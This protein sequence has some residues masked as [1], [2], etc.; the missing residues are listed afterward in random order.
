MA[1]Q[2][3]VD[4]LAP[5]ALVI[6]QFELD[7]FTVSH[8][9]SISL[10]DSIASLPQPKARGPIPD[11]AIILIRAILDAT[12]PILRG[13]RLNSFE[14]WQ[15]VKIEK[16]VVGLVAEVKRRP[17]RSA[18]SPER[19]AASLSGRLQDA[20]VEAVDQAAAAFLGNE[21]TNRLLLLAWSGEW[22]SW[23]LAVRKDSRVKAMPR[24]Q[25]VPEDEAGE[26]HEEAEEVPGEAE[27]APESNAES[28]SQVGSH[29][30]SSE[31]PDRASRSQEAKVE[32][33]YAYKDQLGDV[34]HEKIPY[35][36][37]P[38]PKPKAQQ[39]KSKSKGKGKETEKTKPPP[40]PKK[41]T[42][43]RY[44]PED[45][46]EVMETQRLLT[47]EEC[48][49][50]DLFRF[51]WSDPILFG[52]PESKQNWSLI[53]RFL[54][55]GNTRLNKSKVSGEHDASE[56]DHDASEDDHDAS[57]DDDAS[58]DEDYGDQNEDGGHNEDEDGNLNEVTQVSH[59]IDRHLGCT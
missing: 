22:Y 16:L 50:P 45:L 39:S 20:L 25:V 3:L 36:P 46:A 4:D 6:P 42:F 28:G 9:P 24:R 40:K 30:L 54:E 49:D 2:N 44:T 48:D 32:G 13:M 52:T 35:N 57:E 55:R 58:E 18:K 33:F 59:H 5:T 12:T 31:V 11:F 19:F 27:Q 8:P 41:A 34:A 15:K 47:Q 7:A 53:H 43:R 1:L 10:T 29:E 56:D 37:N 17:T 23:K 21:G 38:N 14:H 26:V 51:K